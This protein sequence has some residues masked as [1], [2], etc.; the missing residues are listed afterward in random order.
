MDSVPIVSDVS[1]EAT[2]PV[3][4]PKP[5]YTKAETVTTPSA[6]ITPTPPPAQAPVVPVP[7]VP[8]ATAPAIIPAVTPSPIKQSVIVPPAGNGRGKGQGES[9]KKLGA[10]GIIAVILVGILI[11]G[12]GVGVVVWIRSS[13][14]LTEINKPLSSPNNVVD[15]VLEPW[16]YANKAITPEP[17]APSV[18]ELAKKYQL[19]RKSIED[20]NYVAFKELVSTQRVWV[21]D[22]PSKQSGLKKDGVDQSVAIEP[23]GEENFVDNSV[24]GIV[25][26]APRL[27]DLIPINTK[28]RT[29][30]PEERSLVIVDD[31]QNSTYRVVFTPWKYVVD[32]FYK[33]KDSAADQGNGFVS[34]VYDKDKWVYNGEFFTVTPHATPRE[35]GDL[36]S[37]GV[38]VEVLDM[39]DSSKVRK[40]VEINNG[41]AVKW[42]NVN[43]LVFSVGK[44]DKHWNSVFLHGDTFIKN[45]KTAG[46]YEYVVQIIDSGN[47][48]RF[49]GVINVK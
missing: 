21:I 16:G 3:V 28:V 14:L 49:E 27:E 12:G 38:V 5:G 9:D 39:A 48:N 36:E 6:P 25:F 11:V 35:L 41:T 15:K 7:V 30:I 40:E 47:V 37:K 32:V 26:N 31:K 17:V 4:I 18:D 46:R 10:G 45:F 23:K 34:F 24:S 20:R 43:G 8:I 1:V 44:P 19:V 29:S 42:V 22:N 2:T 33:T 13:K